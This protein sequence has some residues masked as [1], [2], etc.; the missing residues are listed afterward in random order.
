MKRIV[1]AAVLAAICIAGNAQTDYRA[2]YERQVRNV[3]YSG[4]GVETILDKWEEA[5]PGNIFAIEGRINYHYSKN[6]R[7]DL[8]PMDKMK[9][10][11]KKAVLTM[12]DSLG[13]PLRYFEDVIFDPE[14]F[15]MCQKLID[16]AIESDPM[17]LAY[18]E[19]KVATM[20]AYEKETPELSYAIIKDLVDFDK[21]ARPKWKSLGEEAA[22]GEFESLI[23]E[24][25]FSLFSIGSDQSYLYFKE[26]SAIMAKRFPKNYNFACNVGTYYLVAAND[27]KTALKYYTKVLKSDPENDVAKTNSALARKKMEMNAG[28]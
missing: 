13:R 9:Y 20:I 23:Q 8:V 15:A 6:Q 25:C 17:E 3:G 22:E 21:S 14:E 12:K 11:G 26:I 4:V 5:E 24:F 2:A 16:Q 27:P 18:R 7:T 19:N 28:K 10:M 1:T